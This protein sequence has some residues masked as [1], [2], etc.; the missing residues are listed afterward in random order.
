MGGLTTTAREGRIKLVDMLWEIP[1]C[2]GD[3]ANSRFVLRGQLQHVVLNG[4]GLLFH[5]EPAPNNRQ[6]AF[7]RINLTSAV[8]G[9][10]PDG[11][12]HVHSDPQAGG[13]QVERSVGRHTPALATSERSLRTL[14]S[15]SLP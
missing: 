9:R 6:N 15:P 2:R 11:S 1:T 3:E 12:S 7:H 8:S 5:Q 10:R 13:G 14:S 4:R